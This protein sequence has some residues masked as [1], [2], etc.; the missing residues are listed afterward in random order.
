MHWYDWQL[1]DEEHDEYM[2]E[3]QVMCDDIK[4]LRIDIKAA[5]KDKNDFI[6]SRREKKRAERAAEAENGFGG[7]DEN[8]GAAASQWAAQDTSGEAT[9]GGN[10][11]WQNEGTTINDDAGRSTNWA[12]EM[13]HAQPAPVAASGW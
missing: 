11:D 5:L 12:E 2:A 13:S 4:D 3:L 9:N 1:E 6:D 10:T 8:A 7:N